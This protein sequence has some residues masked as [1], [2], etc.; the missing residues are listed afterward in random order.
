MNY[1]E[2]LT[3]DNIHKKNR[4]KFSIFRFVFSNTF[5]VVVL[6][7]MQILF[8]YIYFN[9]I[10]NKVL[11]YLIYYLE[12]IIVVIFLNL[13][14]TR[15]TIKVSWLYIFLISPTA[16]ALLYLVFILSDL[17]LS[18]K[19]RLNN[20][21]ANSKLL[22]KNY[23][24]DIKGSSFLDLDISEAGF[25]NYFNGFTSFKP[26]TDTKVKYFNEGYDAFIDIFESIEKA[27]K[28]IFIEIFILSDGI[29]WEEMLKLLKGKVKEGVEVKLMFDGLNS[30]SSFNKN[31][32][33]DLSKF[34]IQAKQFN[35]LIPFLSNQHNLRDHRKII[36][37]DNKICYTGGINIADEYAN[38]YERFGYWKDAAIKIEG[39]AVE[40][41][42]IM[43][44]QLWYVD[45]ETNIFDIDKYLENTVSVNNVDNKTHY[46]PYTDYPAFPENIS[47]EIY[48]YLFTTSR[49]YVYIMTPYLVV[50]EG[51]FSTIEAA[52]KHGVDI[53]I[54]VPHI[55][56]KKYVYYVNRSY[57][58]ELVLAGVKIYEYTPGFIHSKVYI[59]DDRR[60]VVGTANLDNRSMYFNYENGLYIYND[61]E[62]ISD[63]KNDFEK[64]FEKCILMDITE[65][66]KGAAKYKILGAIFKIFAPLM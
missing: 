29:I 62:L 21:V 3:K 10:S 23:E 33:N 59:Q 32:C 47:Y 44:F 31:Y 38:L 63:L 7:L 50:D 28:T 55:P 2:I 34:G 60:A 6:M 14:K 16:G 36:I 51:M 53:R 18:K 12:F 41:F 61:C 56:D 37:I 52:A 1:R 13:R 20:L 66:S 40:S 58:K 27:K 39:A 30:L 15:D 35:P 19:S 45:L 54:I 65:I 46:I 25:L 8:L 42:T 4:K 57:Y 43:F 22:Y 48:K 64:T 24:K 17:F 49:D 5:I 9:H 11:Y 26:Y